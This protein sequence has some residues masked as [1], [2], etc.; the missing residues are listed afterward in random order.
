M[1]NKFVVHTQVLEN[2]GAHAESGKFSDGGACLD[3]SVC[4]SSFRRWI[5]GFL[6]LRFRA[7]AA[8][9][10]AVWA[11]ICAWVFRIGARICADRISMGGFGIYLGRHARCAKCRLDRDLWAERVHRILGG[12]RSVAVFT[13]TDFLDGFGFGWGLVSGLEKLN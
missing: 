11:G 12:M 7:G 5:V 10:N 2:Y 13:K 1:F 9:A 6:G 8:T 3:G 4:S